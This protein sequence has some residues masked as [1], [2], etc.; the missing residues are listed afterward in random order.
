MTAKVSPV[1]VNPLLCHPQEQ[2]MSLDG[3]WRFRI[4]PDDTGLSESWFE[5]PER[6]CEP[7]RVPGCW[8]G[9]GYGHEGNDRLWDFLLEARTFKATYTGTGWYAHT[10]AVPSE[11]PG[12]RLWLNF[13][14]I[15]PSADVWLNGENIGSNNLPFVPFGCDVTGRVRAGE[16]NDVVVRVHER[17]REFG[18]AYNWQGNWSG[19][20]RG[21]DLTATGDRSIECLNIYPDVDGGR[22][23]IVLRIGGATPRVEPLALHV[24]VSTCPKNDPVTAQE[25]AVDDSRMEYELAV[26][27]PRLWSPDTPNLYR[28][29]VELRDGDACLDAQVE[30]VGFVKLSS[31][32][33]HFLINGEP[34]YMRG[35]GDFVS[36]P[37]T[38]CPDTD[39]A[40]WRRK[41]RVL[42]DYG[43]NYVRCQSYLYAPEY[44]DAADEVGLLV[45][46]EMGMLGAWGGHT[47]WHVYQWPKPTPDNYPTLKRQW[48]LSV[49]RDVNHPSANLYCMSNEYGKDTDFRRIAWQCYRRTK[50]IK[51]TAFIIWTD[52]GYNPELPGD[53]INHQ[54]GAFTPEEWDAIDKPLIQ[55]E[56]K[57]WSSFPDIRLRDRY[58]GAVR[59]YAID[60]ARDA[61]ARNGQAHLLETYAQN[62]QRLQFLEAKAQ[63]EACRRDHPDM[64]GICHFDA[65]DANPSPQGVVTEFYSR[66]LIDATTWRQTNGDTVVMSSLGIDDRVLQENMRFRCRFFISDFS[67]PPYRVPVLRWRLASASQTLA[68]GELRPRHLPFLTCDAGEIAVTLPS[69]DSPCVLRLEAELVEAERTANNAWDLWLF[70]GDAAWPDHASVYGRAEHTWLREW[71]ELPVAAPDPHGDAVILTEVLDETLMAYMQ[72]GGRVIL[73][74]GEGMVRP[75][76]P[77]FGY[78]KYFFTPPANYAPYEDGQ[79]GTV[80]LDHPMLGDFP[81]DGFADLQC[82]RMI[83]DSPP[84]DLVP[85][86]LADADPVIRVIHRYP[87]C[88]P[89]GYLAERRV[90]KG[91]LIVCAL[92][93]NP[94][95]P[96]ARFLL[97]R[98]CEYA[99]ALE[100]PPREEISPVGLARIMTATQLD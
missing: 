30:R 13:G 90:G 2:R 63:M 18:L 96:E 17:H 26:P 44:F 49:M 34:T 11:W 36:C 54:P 16:T 67:H 37:E 52:G 61:A 73:A 46:S 72:R 32:G 75:H 48:D 38:G 20:Y 7:I 97:S 5:R 42:R 70:P 78:V 35:S 3:A 65:M 9:Q 47:P 79:N 8:Q 91:V 86:D 64:A 29:A 39:R 57:W 60:I 84:L 74:A 69:C 59:P 82:F 83:D 99:L 95:W 12:T 4:D 6:I 88:R 89:L 51:P 55:H 92:D 14:G 10:F 25:F 53:F 81:H 66:K 56:F 22:L 100:K 94:S 21:V 27:S 40:R 19:I 28:V 31:E 41:L 45:Q 33:K 23:R 71:H 85:L 24:S 43:Y 93:L 15:H 87:V 80:I 1:R 68:S 77:N 62:T 98:L 58:D 50:A 76:S